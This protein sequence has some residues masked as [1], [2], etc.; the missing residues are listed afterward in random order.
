MR[1]N[2]NF[3]EHIEK[4]KRNFPLLFAKLATVLHSKDITVINFLTVPL[5][6]EI[7][8]DKTIDCRLKSNELK[9][10]GKMQLI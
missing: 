9:Y 4:M 3:G 10:T 5:L 6:K 2:E 7:C 1:F 8:S